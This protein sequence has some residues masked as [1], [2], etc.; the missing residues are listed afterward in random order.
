MGCW[1]VLDHGEKREIL[2]MHDKIDRYRTPC[3]P[4]RSSGPRS[5]RVTPQLSVI[6]YQLWSF[7][8]HSLVVTSN[9]HSSSEVADEALPDCYAHN[10][11]FLASVREL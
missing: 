1:V 10:L 4:S 9:S 8:R 11:E 2:E 5:L 7:R 3:P 6:S